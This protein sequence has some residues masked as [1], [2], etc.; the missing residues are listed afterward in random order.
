MTERRRP[1]ADVHEP[2]AVIVDM[3]NLLVDAATVRHP[4]GDETFVECLVCGEWEGHTDKCPVPSL[5]Q[6][7]TS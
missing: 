4:N 3:I 1:T 2:P 5:E 7:L 6:W